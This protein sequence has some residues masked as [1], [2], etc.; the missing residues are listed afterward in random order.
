MTSMVNLGRGTQSQQYR[1]AA[2]S[3]RSARREAAGKDRP[4]RRCDELAACPRVE[5]SQRVLDVFV[6]GRLADQEDARDLTVCRALRDQLDDL[7]LSRCES[8]LPPV[9]EPLRRAGQRGEQGVEYTARECALT[10][11]GR[12]D[13]PLERL[14]GD[15]ARRESDETERGGLCAGVDAR[16]CHERDEPRA[17]G[18]PA[19]TCSERRAQQQPLGAP[20]EDRVVAERAV[21]RELRERGKRT[22]HLDT[23]F[24]EACV[25]RA[26]VFRVDH[27]QPR[28]R[29]CAFKPM[30][31]AVVHHS[32]VDPSTGALVIVL[33]AQNP[34]TTSAVSMLVRTIRQ[35]RRAT[36]GR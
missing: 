22:H 23:A 33:G 20:D 4:P 12:G 34:R 25:G 2:A 24:I 14:W 17:R 36:A 5:P 35:R 13:D 9:R 7:I 3:A 15:I 21:P 29:G 31:I 32:P 18:K 26:N 10:A 19:H 16:G 6:G 27:A 30:R 1:K 28:T 8:A 11:R